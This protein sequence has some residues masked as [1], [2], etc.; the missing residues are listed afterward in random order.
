MKKNVVLSLIAFG[1]AIVLLPLVSAFEAH[2]IN[3]TAQIDNN[4]LLDP[5]PDLDFGTAFPQEMLDLTF[6]VS[7]SESIANFNVDD[8]EYVLRQKPKCVNDNDP[9]DHPPVYEDENGNFF[10]PEGSTMMPL[11]CPY[12]SKT[13]ITL[14]GDEGENDG[15]AIP[16]FHGLPGPW[17]LAT[18]L[19]HETFGRLI[20]SANDSQDEWNIDLKVPCFEDHCSQDWSD[21]IRD[22]SENPDIDPEIYKLDPLLEHSIFGCDLWLEVTATSTPPGCE[23]QLD[24]MLV[25]DRSGS[26]DA[27]ELTTL[28]DAANSFVDALAPSVDTVHIG[29]TSFS[30]TG[31]LDLHLTD[32]ASDIHD[33]INALVSGG[34]TNLKKGIELATDELDDAHEHERPATPDVMVILTDGLPNRP[35]GDP[36]GDAAAAADAARAA[37][38]EI[39]VVGIG[40]S[41]ATESYLKTEIADSEAH[42][43]GAADFEDLEPILIGLAECPAD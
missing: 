37:G 41:P 18:T 3:V 23:E 10:C 19:A 39:F 32:V 13:E 26:I 5:I 29:Q 22:T 28:K 6:L 20:A 4:F 38:I 7:L 33:A 35:A 9:S 42:Y 43:F 36:A 34:F 12:L 31:S 24:L 25:L 8:V 30:T 14:D 27:G 1:I 21:F 17:T 16:P 40:V 2:V 15:P 11:L